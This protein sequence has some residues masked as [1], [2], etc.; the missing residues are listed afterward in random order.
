MFIFQTCFS[1]ITYMYMY[2]P[3]NVVYMCIQVQVLP[4]YCCVYFLPA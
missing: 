2:V 3:T 1:I 4:Q